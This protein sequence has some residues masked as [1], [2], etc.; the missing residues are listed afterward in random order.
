MAMSLKPIFRALKYTWLYQR[1]KW[2]SSGAS[3]SSANHLLE[4]APPITFLVGCGRSGTTI[5][6]KVMATHPQISYRF[7]PYHLW[8]AVDQRSDVLNLYH[9]G[10]AQLMMDEDLVSEDS[11][12]L[13]SRLFWP[14]KQAQM[15]LEKTPLNVFRIGYLRALAPHAR[16][17]HIVRDGVDVA[18]SISRLATGSPYKIAGKPDLNQW[19]GIAGEKWNRLQREG[20]QAG[21]W[22]NEVEQ[23]TKESQRGAYEWLTS[24]AEMDRWR[25][26]LGSQLCEIVYE[27]FVEE[28]EQVL[29]QLCDFLGL[30]APAEWLTLAASEIRLQKSLARTIELPEDMAEAFNDYQHRYQFSQS[31]RSVRAKHDATS[32]TEMS[33]REDVRRKS[34]L[35]IVA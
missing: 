12:N 24:L 18:H 31:A 34:E 4:T 35:P 32:Q 28:P 14:S 17:V 5:L 9:Q 13:F 26:P 21:Y 19:W 27:Q 22:P 3:H 8:A 6:G 16:F 23:L 1:A 33:Q 20:A 2:R 25:K 15:M 30:S 29:R 11:H 7:E 10:S